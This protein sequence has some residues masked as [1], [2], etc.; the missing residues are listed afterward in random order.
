MCIRDRAKRSSDQDRLRQNRCCPLAKGGRSA[1]HRSA[2]LAPGVDVPGL[3]FRRGTHG[4]AQS[5]P[6]APHHPRAAPGGDG[7]AHAEIQTRHR[8]W[9]RWTGAAFV[10]PPGYWHSHH[11]ESGTDAYVLP[12]QDAGLH[13]YLRT[14]DIAFSNRGR[15]DAGALSNTP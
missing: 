6:I 13:T 7:V 3:N 8:A 12:I 2:D 9:S 14:L 1:S 5:D 4:S 10:T 15:G 11:N